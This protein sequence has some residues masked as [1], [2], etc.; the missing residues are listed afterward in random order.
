M[1]RPV[2]YG[3]D[4]ST[5]VRTVRMLLAEKGVD[6]EQVPVNVLEGEPKE[7]EHLA[8]HPFGKVPVLDIDGLRLIETPSIL[9]YVNDTVEGPSFVPG[10]PAMRARMD[11]TMSVIDSYGYG[12]MVGVA[13]HHLFPD[14][15][16]GRDDAAQERRVGEAN[17]VL[18]YLM[19]LRG[20]SAFIAGDAPSLADL[21][22]APPVAYVAMTDEAERVFDVPGFED[23]WS[24]VRALDSFAATAPD[25]G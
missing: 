15:I 13:A 19:G 22:L 2:L 23:W 17:K 14:F 8:R 1:S 20:E 18:G 5:Y 16:G 9:R 24:R 12:A 25:P 7:P 3:F 4:G 11:T 21:Y 10:D 6:Y